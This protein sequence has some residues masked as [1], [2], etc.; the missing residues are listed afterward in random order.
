LSIV[1]SLQALLH[2]DAYSF[3]LRLLVVNGDFSS[4]SSS[5]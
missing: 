2:L 5:Y 1:F 4:S 3:C